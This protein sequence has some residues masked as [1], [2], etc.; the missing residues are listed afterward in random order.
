MGIMKSD[1]V[2]V[3]SAW[4]SAPHVESSQFENA[5]IA[6]R[7]GPLVQNLAGDANEAHFR[8]HHLETVVLCVYASVGYRERGPASTSTLV[9]KGESL[10]LHSVAV[11]SELHGD[12][13]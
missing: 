2:S 5:D 4:S 8:I 10:P 11:P 12:L 7:H 1:S 9:E 13:A 3:T 6:L